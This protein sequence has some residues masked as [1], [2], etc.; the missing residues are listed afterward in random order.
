MPGRQG[1]PVGAGSGRK[2][3]CLLRLRFIPSDR[4][5]LPHR[6]RLGEVELGDLT[7]QDTALPT[8]GEAGRVERNAQLR[9]RCVVVEHTPR[10]DSSARLL[11]LIGFGGVARDGEVITRATPAA[12]PRGCRPTAD[13]R[14]Y[15]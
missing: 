1:D 10:P 12:A 6:L 5:G 4:S 14:A 2:V 13:R 8:C 11:E 15:R 7:D 3:E 9:R